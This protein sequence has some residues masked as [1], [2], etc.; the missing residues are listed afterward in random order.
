[1]FQSRCWNYSFN[2]LTSLESETIHLARLASHNPPD[3]EPVLVGDSQ[4]VLNESDLSDLQEKLETIKENYPEINTK[5]SG[6][7]F[8]VEIIPII[9]NR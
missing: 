5:Q 8:D 1:M 7:K 2:T 6:G 9:H 4:R 3:V